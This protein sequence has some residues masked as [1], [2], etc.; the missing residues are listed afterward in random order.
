MATID[1]LLATYNGEKYLNE[2]IDSIFSQTSQDWRLWIRDD[3]SL[4]KTKEILA[5][6]RNQYPDKVRI[7]EDSNGQLG[8]NGNFRRLLHASSGEYIM[9][10]DQDDVWLPN[11]IDWKLKKMRQMEEQFGGDKPLLVFS[12]L[13]VV[14]NSLNV[15]NE[16]YW[17]YS[18]KDP[19]KT[20]FNYLLS[21]FVCPGCSLLFNKK[22]RE[23]SIDRSGEGTMHDWWVAVH[24][25]I[26]GH[27]AFIDTPTSFYRQH[28]ENVFGIKRISFWETFKKTLDLPSAI[29]R[30]KDSNQ[31]RQNQARAFYEAYRESEYSNTAW[32]KI[33]EEYAEL[34]KKN[35]FQ[36]KS[37]VL[38]YRIFG[39]TF[40]KTLKEVLL[41]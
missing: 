2:Q 16:S 4:D 5:D 11:K 12:D 30:T 32:L 20:S 25:S 10:C 19:K 24:A 13:K 40:F 14:D 35:F 18:G 41:V 38:K 1:I 31:R 27:I 9:F 15:I 23:I 39:G 17:N 33:A 28:G 37:F 3:G 21:D 6:Y 29:Q 34:A 7:I 26:F 8:C 22:L 36:R